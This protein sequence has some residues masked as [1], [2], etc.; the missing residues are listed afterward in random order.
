MAFAGFKKDKDRNDVIAYLKEAVCYFRALFFPSLTDI[1]PGRLRKPQDDKNSPTFGL[2]ML[3]CRVLVP[4]DA[5]IPTT[6]SR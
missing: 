3:H 4:V 6:L 5:P 1:F 2:D